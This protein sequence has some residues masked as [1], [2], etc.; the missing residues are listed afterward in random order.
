MVFSWGIAP[1]HPRIYFR[2]T[3]HRPFVPALIPLMPDGVLKP[4]FPDPQLKLPERSLTRLKRLSV[5]HWVRVCEKS[6]RP[7]SSEKLWKLHMLLGPPPIFPYFSC[8]YIYTTMLFNLNT[9]TKSFIGARKH[10]C[11]R[12]NGTNLKNNYLNYLF[13]HYL[14]SND[15]WIVSKSVRSQRAMLL[16]I[17]TLY[18]VITWR[19]RENVSILWFQFKTMFSCFLFGGNLFFFIN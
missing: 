17:M 8:T 5:P 10:V 9:C 2:I 1:R 15:Q 13:S 19:Y 14:A 16:L 12:D 7:K 4:M 3:R 11:L 6:I 18:S